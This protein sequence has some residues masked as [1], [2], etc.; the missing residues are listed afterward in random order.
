MSYWRWHMG[1]TNIKWMFALYEFGL[2]V[3]SR[4]ARWS[5]WT[6]QPAPVRPDLPG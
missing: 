1:N 4:L 5:R 3:G 6:G 2:R